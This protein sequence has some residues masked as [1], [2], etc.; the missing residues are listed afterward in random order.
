[1]PG[2]VPRMPAMAPPRMAEPRPQPVAATGHPGAGD[3][4]GQPGQAAASGSS[5]YIFK[6]S[7]SCYCQFLCSWPTLL[8]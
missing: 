2:P 1:M 3:N 7:V 5:S 6:C 4:L 8:E